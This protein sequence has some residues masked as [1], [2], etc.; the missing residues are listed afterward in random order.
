M[1]RMHPAYCWAESDLKA[2]LQAIVFSCYRKSALG[3]SLRAVEPT[4]YQLRILVAY[5]VERRR[6]KVKY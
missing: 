6:V 1:H 4:S 3:S 2:S 5:F